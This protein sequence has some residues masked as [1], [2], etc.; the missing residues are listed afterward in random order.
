MRIRLFR[1]GDEVGLYRV[2]FSAVHSVCV[3]DYSAAQCAAWAPPDLDMTVWNERMHMLMPFVV[4]HAGALVAYADL[5]PSG[6]I[7][8]F[9]VASTH[10]RQGAGRLLMEKIHADAIQSGLTELSSHVSLTAEPFFRR[11]GFHVLQRRYPKRQG[12]TLEYAR[13]QKRLLR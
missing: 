7:D 3:R 2:F 4:E 1:P 6:Y 12:V 10:Q 8:H 11:H 5:Q 9:Y 13:M